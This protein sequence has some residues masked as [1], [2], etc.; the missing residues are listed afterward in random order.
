MANLRMIVIVAMVLAAA[1]ATVWL[2]YHARSVGQPT[3]MA[4]IGPGLLILGLVVHLRGRK[5]P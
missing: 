1:G 2:A 4:A 3:W 5:R